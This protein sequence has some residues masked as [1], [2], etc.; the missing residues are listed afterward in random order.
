MKTHIYV[1]NIKCGGCASTITTKVSAIENISYVEVDV[2][3][4]KVS[5]NCPDDTC[6]LDV[7]ST[8]KKWGYPQFGIGTKL[9]N[10]KSFVSCIIGRIDG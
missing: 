9:D 3:S 2:E 7:I 8:L 10:A 5:F 1:D 4:G 6:K